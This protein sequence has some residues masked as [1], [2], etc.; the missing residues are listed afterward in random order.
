MLLYIEDENVDALAEELTKVTGTANKTEAVRAALHEHL[1]AAQKA[2]M[3]Q[4]HILAE[5]VTTLHGYL[6]VV[7]EDKVAMDCMRTLETLVR[8][9]SRESPDAMQHEQPFTQFI[10]ELQSRA[11]EIGPLDPT[12]D[13]K[14]FTDDM[15][16]DD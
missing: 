1:D 14:K 9:A 10:H 6:A 12:F 13:M 11:D 4:P 5:C 2:C 15:W 7:L 3:E 16:G 8:A